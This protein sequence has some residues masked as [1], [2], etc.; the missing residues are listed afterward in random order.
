MSHASNSSVV[1]MLAGDDHQGGLRSE[2][3]VTR[4]EHKALVALRL[5]SRHHYEAIEQACRA[6]P[7][8]AVL[9]GVCANTS[10]FF[11]VDVFTYRGDATNDVIRN[12]K[13]HVG[14]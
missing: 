7:D 1:R 9:R 13:V 6:D 5:T 2:H 12:S 10:R 4:F 3:I 11:S 14:E 8:Q